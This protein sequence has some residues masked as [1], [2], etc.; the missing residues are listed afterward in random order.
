MLKT[1][2]LP[3]AGDAQCLLEVRIVPAAD[4]GWDV[5]ATLDGHVLAARHCL[6]WHRTERASRLMKF[7]GRRMQV[8]IDEASTS[9]ERESLVAL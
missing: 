3:T 7:Q 5:T 8:L 6:D 2:E 9:K 1:V 4:G